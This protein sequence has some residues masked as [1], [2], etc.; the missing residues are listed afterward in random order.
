[1]QLAMFSSAVRRASR[2]RSQGFAR[3]LLTRAGT[4]PSS[5][6][7][8]LSAIGPAGWFGRTSPAS[9]RLTMGEPSAPSS[10]GWQNS[11]MG[12]PTEALT[13]STSVWP[14]GA[15]V[16][17]LSDILETGDVPRRY[18]LSAKACAG[19]LRRAARRGKDLP[20]QLLQALQAVAGELS[21]LENPEG[22]I[23]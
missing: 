15:S 17:S 5:I 10:G 7:A 9:V 12:G 21:G 3:A 2:S 19:I 8:L 16:C 6:L 20:M 11:G 14:S 23:Q 13:L 22:K 18:F 1:M 4:L